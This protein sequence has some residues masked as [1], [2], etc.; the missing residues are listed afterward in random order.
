MSDSLGLKGNPYF[1]FCLQPRHT[2]RNL[3]SGG[4][5]NLFPFVLAGLLGSTVVVNTL[6][7]LIADH[8]ETS[9]VLFV[10]L[11][12]VVIGVMNLFLISLVIKFVHRFILSGNLFRLRAL[13]AP[14]AIDGSALRLAVGWSLL[15][16]TF[17]SSLSALIFFISLPKEF[18]NKPIV[19]IESGVPYPK[20]WV[21]LVLVWSLGLIVVTTSEVLK[22]PSWKAALGLFLTFVL[23]SLPAWKQF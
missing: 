9:R 3:L 12:G 22:V 19:Y 1:N 8:M 6:A 4:Y 17:L 5:S 13:V 23:I 7:P 2:I 21:P 11:Y 20:V 16:S 18:S 14:P 10:I 15:P